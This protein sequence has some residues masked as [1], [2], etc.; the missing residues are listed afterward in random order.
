MPLHYVCT[1]HIKTVR[2]EAIDSVALHMK[3]LLA[4]VTWMP[5]WFST[6]LMI[7]IWRPPGPSTCAHAS[8]EMLTRHLLR[9]PC[10]RKRCTG[11]LRLQWT[12][13][14]DV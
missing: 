2:F 3:Q 10:D 14:L 11:G 7:R 1:A 9:C 6:L 13:L 8:Q 12:Q 5:S 4:V